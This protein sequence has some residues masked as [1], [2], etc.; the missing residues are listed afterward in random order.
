M[1]ELDA[2][3][4]H[5]AI[6]SLSS[7]NYWNQEAP[8]F[9]SAHVAHESPAYF[10]DRVFPFRVWARPYAR[11]EPPQTAELQSQ[12]VRHLCASK[13][14]SL[15]LIF[16][17]ALV[18]PLLHYFIIPFFLAPSQEHFRIAELSKYCNVKQNCHLNFPSV[19]RQIRI[20]ILCFRSHP[21]S[22]QSETWHPIFYCA[23]QPKKRLFSFQKLYGFGESR[24]T[25]NSWREETAAE[26]WSGTANYQQTLLLSVCKVHYRNSTLSSGTCLKVTF[27]NYCTNIKWALVTQSVMWAAPP[28]GPI[29]PSPS[30][31]SGT[32]EQL[33]LAGG[34][35]LA[36]VKNFALKQLSKPLEAAG[37]LHHDMI[38][39]L[40]YH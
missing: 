14:D 37:F 38:Y 27:S 32:T 40:K 24:L 21:C 29:M 17:A 13:D 30:G 2:N 10:S 5:C 35:R 16:S 33:V 26:R 12:A 8:V 19:N 34:K 1:L 11:S 9:L 25:K 39:I 36:Q 22:P 20:E 28:P 15:S 7:D 31:N 23:R 6:A 4:K 3:Q 18:A